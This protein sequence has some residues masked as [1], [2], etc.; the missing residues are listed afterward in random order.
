[1]RPPSGYNWGGFSDAEADAIAA[2]AKVEFDATAQDALLA[3]LHARIVDQAMWLWVVHDLNPRALGRRCRAIVE[4]QSWF[5]DLTPVRVG[6]NAMHLYVLRRLLYTIPIIIGVS[7]VC[8]SFIHLAPGDPISAVLPENAS[9]EV[10]A[11]I[12]AAYGFDKPLPMQ[13]LIW[14]RNV[15]QGDFGTSIMTRRPVRARL[16]RPS[17]TPR[18]SRV[19]AICVELR[20]R[21]HALGLLAGLHAR[22]A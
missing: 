11:Q 8:F 20:A 17:P 7:L 6:V 5:Q 9:A 16:R 22:S 2:R 21:H 13:Y 18:C 15:L 14:L 3:R 10:M 4:A 19:S 12:K 1:M